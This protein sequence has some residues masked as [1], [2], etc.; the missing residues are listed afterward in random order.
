MVYGK[1]LCLGSGLPSKH[2]YTVEKHILVKGTI[3][4]D[5]YVSVLHNFGSD[6]RLGLVADVAHVG[7]IEFKSGIVFPAFDVEFESRQ[8]SYFFLSFLDYIYIIS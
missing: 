4:I 8:H 3:D 1:F 7:Y 2:Y 6:V 5:N